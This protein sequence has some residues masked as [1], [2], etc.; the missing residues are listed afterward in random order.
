MTEK[1]PLFRPEAVAHHALARAGGNTKL[2]LRESR[3]VW[4][5]RGLLVALALAVL[6]VFAVRADTF[7]TGDVVVGRDGVAATGVVRSS[8]VA[9]G[10][11]VGVEIGGRESH[12]TVSTVTTRVVVTLHEP[13]PPGARGDATI[14]SG[15]ASVA[16][17][18]LNVGPD[19]LEATV[20]VQPSR[21]REWKQVTVE[22]GGRELRGEVSAVIPQMAVTL[23]EKF[24]PGARGAATISTGDA[25]VAALLLGWD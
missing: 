9:V 20:A 23:H 14:S 2:D 8:R 19:G 22:I 15:D 1:R 16:A 4:L 3:T 6:L 24:P 10:Q 5:F 21:V 25:S 11:R 12:G 18:D 17:V 7:A 13:F